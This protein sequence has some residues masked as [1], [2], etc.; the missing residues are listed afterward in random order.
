MNDGYGE[1]GLLTPDWRRKEVF[2]LDHAWL[3]VV[4]LPLA[5]EACESLTIYSHYAR[6][7]QAEITRFTSPLMNSKSPGFTPAIDE[8]K[9]QIFSPTLL[10][11]FSIISPTIDI[12]HYLSKAYIFPPSSIHLAG[13]SPSGLD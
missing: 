9:S 5:V 12:K 4:N 13:S 11:S 10:F 6:Y 8:F 7:G 1:Y 3:V 2:I